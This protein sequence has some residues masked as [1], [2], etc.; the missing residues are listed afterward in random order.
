MSINTSTKLQS[1]CIF[2]SDTE[3]E[4][5]LDFVRPNKYKYALSKFRLSSHN[6]AIETGRYDATPR[7]ER[8]CV[9]C[10][11]NAI[12]NE[13]HFLL[14]CPFYND[15]RRKYL[16]PYYCRWPTINKFKSLMQN[17]NKQAIKKLSQFL[18]FANVRRETIV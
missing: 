17:T 1:Y 2:K 4:S 5:Y 11:M 3:H 15:I 13:Y 18:Y 6:L 16:S 12:E 10:N 14:A 9:Y 7:D 8:V